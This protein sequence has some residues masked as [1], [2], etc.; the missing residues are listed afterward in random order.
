MQ[1]AQMLQWCARGGLK[2]SQRR[3]RRIFSESAV[4]EAS[5]GTVPGSVST[6]RTC[7]TTASSSK[8]LEPPVCSTPP[9]LQPSHGHSMCVL[10]A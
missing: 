9:T 8:A 7:A 1:R 3:Q 2:A 4:G 5:F 6:A 10:S